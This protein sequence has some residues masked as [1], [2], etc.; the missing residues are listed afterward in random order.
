V[1]SKKGSWHGLSKNM[2][3]CD[4]LADGEGDGDLRDKDDKD[5]IYKDGLL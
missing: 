3:S 2:V 5:D 4:F 1:K